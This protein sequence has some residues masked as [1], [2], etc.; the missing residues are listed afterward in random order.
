MLV[1]LR[2]VP[3]LWILGAERVDG[4]NLS[5]LIIFLDIYTKIYVSNKYQKKNYSIAW[6]NTKL[7]IYLNLYF[8]Y[9]HAKPSTIKKGICSFVQTFKQRMR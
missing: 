6:P 5:E 8:T 1:V 7:C 9:G 4:N 3:E 2:I